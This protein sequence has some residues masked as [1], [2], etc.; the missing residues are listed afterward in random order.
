M[1]QLSIKK[2][3]T[4]QSIGI[5]SDLSKVVKENWGVIWLGATRM[6]LQINQDYYAPERVQIGTTRLHYHI[7]V[8]YANGW[9]YSDLVGPTNEQIERTVADIQSL[10]DAGSENLTSSIRLEVTEN[11]AK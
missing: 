9:R 8:K 3:G 4:D 5:I 1:V 6:G 11:K 7:G 10:I 2:E